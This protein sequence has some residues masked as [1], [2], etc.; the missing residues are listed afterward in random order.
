MNK[1]MQFERFE[2]VY[3]LVPLLLARESRV[4]VAQSLLVH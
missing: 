3:Y 1:K 4:V 2:L